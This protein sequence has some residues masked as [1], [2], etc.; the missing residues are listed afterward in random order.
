[1]ARIRA[2]LVGWLA[3]KLRERVALR[4]DPDV[5]IGG[6]DS[7][8][9]LRWFVIPRN[10]CLN[11]YLHEFHRSDDDRALHDHPWI[12]CSLLLDGEYTEH[13]IAASGIHERV[14]RRAGDV[15]VRTAKHAHRIELHAGICTTLFITGPRL[16]EW[17]F[18]CPAGWVPWRKFTSASGRE[19]GRGCDQ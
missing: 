18:H 2:K 9:L 8:Y 6:E 17:G 15:I 4:R 1:M 5:I 11:V 12:N 16:R 19:V 14:V 7:P 3:R 13:T 10:R